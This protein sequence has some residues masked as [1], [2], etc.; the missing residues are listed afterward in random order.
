MRGV[1]CGP[2][3]AVSM[4]NVAEMAWK[5]SSPQAGHRGSE[6]ANPEGDDLRSVIQ[7][8][9]ELQIVTTDVQQLPHPLEVARMDGRACFNFNTDQ[10]AAF[11]LYDDV[12]LILILVSR[13]YSHRRTM[14]SVS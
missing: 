6:K 5:E 1:G 3:H 7:H 4:R 2:Y 13:A 11:I 10:S 9:P 8:E 12:D 14:R